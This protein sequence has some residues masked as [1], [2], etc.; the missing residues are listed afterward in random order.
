MDTADIWAM[1]KRGTVVLLK[2]AG[3]MLL[4]ISLRNNIRESKLFKRIYTINKYHEWMDE[5]K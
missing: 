3:R 5:N 2:R 4:P 1:W